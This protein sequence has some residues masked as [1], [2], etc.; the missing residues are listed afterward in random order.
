MTMLVLIHPASRPQTKS[1][2]LKNDQFEGIGVTFSRW[3]DWA[4][5]TVDDLN[6]LSEALFQLESQRDRI[7][8][9]GLPLSSIKEGQH[10]NRKMIGST[11]N[12]R[13]NH[14]QW[15]CIDIDNLDLPLDYADFNSHALD[16][17]RYATQGLPP[18][19]HGI[20]FHFQFS[21]SMG[22]KPGIRIHLWYWLDR[23]ISD[24]EA[25]GW[26]VGAEPKVDLS[27]Y[28]P[29]Q[30]H[31]T[32]APIFEPPEADPVRV[33][34]GPVDCGNGISSVPVPNHL[35]ERWT[36]HQSR[37][38]RFVRHINGGGVLEPQEI[39]RNDVGLV[40]DGRE[41]FLFLKSVDAAKE[42]CTGR[43]LPK[44]APSV[45]EL[46]AK[47]WELFED[48]AN[49]DDGRWTF[50]DALEKAR[51]RYEEIQGGW[52]P[53][54]RNETTSLI[55]DVAP[56]FHLD[57]LSVDEGNERLD[58][59]LGR[60]FHSV[61]VEDVN[62][63][64]MAL[65]VT[66]GSGKTTRTIEQLK[67]L[68]SKNPNLNVEVYLPRHGLIRELLPKLHDIDRGMQVIHMR[69]RGEEDENGATSCV[70]YE[71][72]RSLE[73]AGISIR[74]NACWRSEAEKCEHYETCA[75]QKQFK[76]DAMRGGAIRFLPHAYLG[77][78]RNEFTPD[79]DLIIIDEAFL[80][81]IHEKLCLSSETVRR[82]FAGT[83]NP[84]LGSLIV[85]FL[86]S[87]EPL[88]GR[89]RDH[90]VSVE[91]LQSLDFKTDAERI[92]FNARS[93][94]PARGIKGSSYQQARFADA[95]REILIEELEQES[96][97]HVSRIRFD[98]RTNDVI[99][100]RL[101]MPVVPDEANLL[102]L[103]ATADRQLLSHLFGDI[104]F[105]YIDFQQKAIVAQVHDRTGSNTSWNESED[106]FE[107][108]VSVLREH[109]SIGDRVLCVSHKALADRLRDEIKIENLAIEHFGNLRGIDTYKDY[110][111]IFITGRNQPPQSEVDGLARAV[112][113]ND[114]PP[115]VH[116][117]AGLLG[118]APETNLPT[119]LRGYLTTDPDQQAGV[120]VR[121]FSDPRIEI[122][123][124]QI[125]EAE[126]VQAMARLRL[127]HANKPKHIYLLGNL[128]IEMPI[129]YLV[130]WDELMPSQA[131]RELM[132]KGNIPM[133][134]A[135]WLKMRPDL[136][137]NEEQAKKA[138]QRWGIQDQSRLLRAS[139]VM[140]R[141]NAVVVSFRQVNNGKPSGRT[142]HHLFRIPTDQA[143]IVD[144]DFVGEVPFADWLKFLSGGDPE[145]DESGW[146]EVIIVGHDW[147]EAPEQLIPHLD[148]D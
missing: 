129:D 30:P 51:R 7:V 2:R 48:E 62:P 128:P 131:D 25:K 20:D 102:V 90:G 9:R 89:L 10:I 56:Y 111:T 115:L 34:S 78:P 15:L 136:V 37:R 14:C 130:G 137:K 98:P 19:F 23:P 65:R 145:I 59:H 108:L 124:Q 1:F 24:D 60:F 141:F 43:K 61:L 11:A 113:W 148:T 112:W 31:F 127:V 99:L 26:L 147:I 142:H 47:T 82:I 96:R 100:D 17:A 121:S 28:T 71:Y 139:P 94:S 49:L 79:P 21:A 93:N 80:S 104:E 101:T 76:S 5:L 44:D 132:A 50:H 84:T 95:L 91:W 41:R 85:D 3:Y 87:G 118:A 117:D 116:D 33:R 8:V 54:G 35:Q 58:E 83:D 53:N 109:M 81:A 74:P 134:P 110:Q 107:D 72:V 63:T 135:G 45:D 13:S 88:L 120:Y 46:A 29:I 67:I 75:Y 105:H 4:R 114:E 12:I 106:R 16:I 27:L 92:P 133:T 55:P 64:R 22:I 123:H 138:N 77:Q 125:R 140:L 97:G 122:L 52:K 144:G 70:R 119:D 39:V 73:E 40:I 36:E 66:M 57:A 143:D 103:D 32:A 68:C 86:I 6:S 146:G 38:T 18:E 126:T 42:I 69:G